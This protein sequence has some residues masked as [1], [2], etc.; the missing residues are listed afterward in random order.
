MSL[1]LPRSKEYMR[2]TGKPGTVVSLPPIEWRSFK[3]LVSLEIAMKREF[4]GTLEAAVAVLHALDL[5]LLRRLRLY[6]D[7]TV[8]NSGEVPPVREGPLLLPSLESVSAQAPILADH[9][10]RLCDPKKLNFWDV[11][12]VYEIWDPLPDS[13]E[14]FKLLLSRGFRYEAASE[15]VIRLMPLSCVERDPA[16]LHPLHQILHRLNVCAYCSQRPSSAKSRS[17]DRFL[18]NWTRYR[19]CG[20]C[21]AHAV[22][23]HPELV[24]RNL[25]GDREDQFSIP[26]CLTNRKL[27]SVFYSSGRF[28]NTLVFCGRKPDFAFDAFARERFDLRD[29]SC[30]VHEVLFKPWS[31]ITVIQWAPLLH[32]HGLHDWCGWY[33]A[34]RTKSYPKLNELDSCEAGQGGNVVIPV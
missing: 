2:R 34:I 25:S 15:S 5:P 4:G 8:Y 19:P 18:D 3:N 30:G 11:P 28:W 32:R 6:L 33:R 23:L 9:V 12:R 1:R 29:P 14:W 20:E 26:A 27:L 10:S 16:A 21:A 7:W 24:F 13:D 17:F 31:E 22:S